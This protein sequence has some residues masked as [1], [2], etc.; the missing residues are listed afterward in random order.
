[1]IRY[2]IDRLKAGECTT[3]M[4]LTFV[5]SLLLWYWVVSSLIPAEIL[6]DLVDGPFM[7]CSIACGFMY[8]RWSIVNCR[9]VLT[10]EYVLRLGIVMCWLPNAAWRIERF[11]YAQGWIAGKVGEHDQLRGWFIA[12]LVTGVIL[13]I[14]CLD[15]K[16][17]GWPVRRSVMV[18]SFAWLFGFSFMVGI[19]WHDLL[20]LL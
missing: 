5:T 6:N 1:M 20:A 10:R 12:V 3:C 19:H 11:A 2:T 16:D 15:L 9:S 18:A 17:N 7:T 8:M 13:H 4:L 14:L